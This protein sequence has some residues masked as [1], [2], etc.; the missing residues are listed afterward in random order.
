MTLKQFNTIVE[1]IQK[2]HR[3]GIMP[4]LQKPLRTESGIRHHHEI[5]Y[6]DGTYDTI[7]SEVW[8]VKLRGPGFNYRFATNE[9]VLDDFKYANLN[10]WVMAFLNGEWNPNQYMKSKITERI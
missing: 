6:I 5:R 4:R 10:D 8:A 2:H 9:E 7:G 3:F 1:L